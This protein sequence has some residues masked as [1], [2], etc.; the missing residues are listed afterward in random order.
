[1]EFVTAL[2]RH[3][4]MDSLRQLLQLRSAISRKDQSPLDGSGHLEIA[5]FLFDTDLPINI[6][7]LR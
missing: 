7:L 4:V 6:F 2:S 5:G 1:M 3:A